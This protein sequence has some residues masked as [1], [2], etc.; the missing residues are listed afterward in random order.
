MPQLITPN[1]NI[2]CQPGWCLQYVRQTFRLAGVHPTAT[3]AWESSPTQHPDRNFPDAWV[4]VW[5]GLAN[6]PAGHVVLRAPNGNVYSTSDLGSTPH[7]H[8]D[9]GDLERYYAYYGMPL[10]YRGWTEDIEN[11]AVMTPNFDGIASMG[12]V[13][14]ITPATTAPEGDALTPDQMLELK[15]FIQSDNEAKAA[16]TRA[17]VVNQLKLWIQEQCN[18]TGDRVINM[19]RADVTNTPAAVLNAQFN[20]PGGAPTN[21]AGILSAIHAQP[22][23]GGVTA[24]PSAVVRALAVQLNK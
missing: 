12:D 16:A 18:G 9:L 15:L 2:P 5:Y 11:V 10:T 7:L 3:A 6:E 22:V 20:L 4:P 21:L 19:V 17:D 14:A 24:D 13:T 1:P 8:P 23:T